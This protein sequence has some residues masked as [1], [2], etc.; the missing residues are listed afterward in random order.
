MKLFVTA[1]PGAKQNRVEKIDDTHYRVWVK[2]PPREGKANE[3]VI[4]LLSD[5]LDKPR[6]AFRLL[7]G[8]QSKNKCFEWRE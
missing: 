3:A 1:K 4:A 6:S 7:T 5:Y 8:A 2:A